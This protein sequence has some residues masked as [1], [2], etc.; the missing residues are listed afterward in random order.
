[1]PPALQALMRHSHYSTTA[2]YYVGAS[3]DEVASDLWRN[4]APQADPASHAG[5]VGN[6]SGNIGQNTASREASENERKPLQHNK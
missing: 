4:H 1:M 2:A 5:Q 3:A 6:K